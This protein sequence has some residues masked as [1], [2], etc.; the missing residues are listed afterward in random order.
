MHPRRVFF[1]MSNEN[2]VFRSAPIEVTESVETI[3]P[4]VDI[5]P[6]TS[7]V[8]SDTMADREPI[9]GD[10]T[11]AATLAAMGVDTRVDVLDEKDKDNLK[12][13]ASYI[14]ELIRQK[15]LANNQHS[16][17]KVMNELRIDMNIDFEA[18]PSHVL[19]R[20]GG[21]VKSWR[22]IAFV[23]DPKERRSLFMK[24]AK[25]GTSEDM[26]KFVFQQMESRKI[27]H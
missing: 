2:V 11:L 25:M 10:A 7:R 12:E 26:N 6:D 21:M 4:P 13:V 24:L 27:W 5:I 3:A 20:I 23:K 15:G 16:F 8:T 18:E 9:S 17:Y 14:E 19:D 22:D 1:C